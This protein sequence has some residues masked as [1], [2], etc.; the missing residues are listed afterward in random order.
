VSLLEIR[1][2]RTHIREARANG[3]EGL[4]KRF[5][6]LCGEFRRT[7]SRVTREARLERSSF[8]GELRGLLAETCVEMLEPDLVIMDEFQRF[9]H[10][11][12][13]EDDA[14]VLARQ[15][16]EFFFIRYHDIACFDQGFQSL[17]TPPRVKGAW[18]KD[19]KVVVAGG[20]ITEYRVVMK[21]TF[22]LTD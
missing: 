14:S 9:K 5:E 19:Q 13:G 18:I 17:Y 8:I 2:L 11:M 3:E 15:L 12:S 21:V 10:L 20:K 1:N 16:F 7:D 6:W 4:R 22:V